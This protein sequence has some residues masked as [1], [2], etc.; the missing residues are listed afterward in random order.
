MKISVYSQAAL[1]IAT[2]GAT[3]QCVADAA[4]G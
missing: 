1:D 2:C 4:F 3:G